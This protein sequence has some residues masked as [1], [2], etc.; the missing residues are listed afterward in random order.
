MASSSSPAGSTSAPASS[1]RDAL[2]MR[3]EGP[4]RGRLNRLAPPATAGRIGFCPSYSEVGH[5]SFGVNLAALCN[6]I[7]FVFI[8]DC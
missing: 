6:L 4:I 3:R 1:G 5:A 2:D 8:D 7:F